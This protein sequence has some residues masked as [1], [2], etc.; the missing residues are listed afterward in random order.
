M[1]VNRKRFSRPALACLI[2]TPLS[3]AHADID[4]ERLGTYSQPEPA[5]A[6]DE[7]A[8]EIV[9]FDKKS[10]SLFVTNGNDKTIDIIDISDPPLLYWTA[11][12]TSQTT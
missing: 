10:E 8:A 12:L 2:A 4:L 1:P 11:P 9:A 3:L 6:F 5:A 7:S